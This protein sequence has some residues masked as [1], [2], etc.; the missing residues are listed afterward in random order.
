[1]NVLQKV[2]LYNEYRLTSY[3][4]SFKMATP[5]EHMLHPSNFHSYSDLE[6]ASAKV[7]PHFVEQPR[8]AFASPTF[9]E[10][11][12]SKFSWANNDDSGKKKSDYRVPTKRRRTKGQLSKAAAS[13]PRPFKVARTTPKPSVVFF[14]T[15]EDNGCGEASAIGKNEHAF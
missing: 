4:S 3:G 7:H 11:L 2:Q 13:E 9:L 12:V 15:N 6:M 14:P 8:A 1:M 10:D 5:T